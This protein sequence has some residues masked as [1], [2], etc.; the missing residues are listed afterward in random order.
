[1]LLLTLS[2]CLAFVPDV[3]S[4][5]AKTDIASFDG[6]WSM[7][8]GERDG[9]PISADFMKQARRVCKNGETTV[10]FGDQVFLKARF[11]IDPSKKPKTIDYKVL[12]GPNKDKTILGIYDL[13]G[14]TL[15]FCFS[16]PDEK[17]P[18]DFKS[19]EGSG[20]TLSEWK[21]VKK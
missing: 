2:V 6:E 12:E 1:M 7:V 17:R 14:D 8:S 4:D 11:T 16:S 20:W 3:T 5:A 15:K 10:S 21:R 9:Q 19:R 18:T 13:N